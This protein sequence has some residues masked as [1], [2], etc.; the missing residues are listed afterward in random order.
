MAIDPNKIP[1]RGY[2]PAS[3]VSRGYYPAPSVSRGYN[4]APRFSGYED[5]WARQS[6]KEIPVTKPAPVQQETREE[7]RQE[8]E[9]EKIGQTAGMIPAYFNEN[10][11]KAKRSPSVR[12][13]VLQ[14]RNGV[15]GSWFL[16]WRPTV[17]RVASLQER[18]TDTEVLEKKGIV[19]LRMP[20]CCEGCVEKVQRKLKSLKGVASVECSQ[21]KQKVVV[22]GS[23]SPEDV[24]KRAKTA[25]PRSTF[26]VEES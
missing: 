21:E 5:T 4:P 20:L 19:E 7:K 16:H 25:L 23:A 12:N 18:S 6:W 10:L 9:G 14:E 2:N 15:N 1:N 24:L 13:G 22:R 26:W 17:T 3:S 8:K 11:F